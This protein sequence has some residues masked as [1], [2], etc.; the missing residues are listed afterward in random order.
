MYLPIE[1]WKADPRW[2]DNG[3]NC[4]KIT[5]DSI[6]SNPCGIAILYC[7]MYDE[8]INMQHIRYDKRLCV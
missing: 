2:K 5:V 7:S 8:E 6:E 4:L 1:I 3:F